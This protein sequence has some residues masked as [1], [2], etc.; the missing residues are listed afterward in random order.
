MGARNALERAGASGVAAILSRPRFLRGPSIETPVE[1]R[2]ITTDRLELRAHTLADTEAWHEIVSDPHVVRYMSW[3]LRDRDAA[4]RHLRDCTRHT[5]L[6]QADD[7]LALAVVRENRLVGDVS[8]QLRTVSSD[9]RTVELGWVVAPAH[10]GHGYATEAV[11]AILDLAFT[12][13]QARM[14]T[15]V[16]HEANSASLALAQRLGF[17]E[18]HRRVRATTS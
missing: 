10:Q 7:F 1:A 5:R 2:P 13:V 16:I 11:E 8:L 14:A 17:I 4:R 6:W 12:S 9:V 3:P 15:A 18:V